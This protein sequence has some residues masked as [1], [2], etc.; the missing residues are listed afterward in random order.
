MREGELSDAWRQ[1]LRDIS[2]SVIL[3]LYAFL[4]IS[5]LTVAQKI[6][7]MIETNDMVLTNLKYTHQS[8]VGTNLNIRHLISCWC[9]ILI[10]YLCRLSNIKFRSLVNKN[11][12]RY[13]PFVSVR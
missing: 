3:A 13:F 12:E 6:T 7:K 4:I 9:L 1:K 2:Y 5:L 8:T 10:G 11:C